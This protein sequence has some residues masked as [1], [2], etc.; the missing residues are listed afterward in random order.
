MYQEIMNHDID[1]AI[2]CLGKRTTAWFAQQHQKATPELFYHYLQASRSGCF[3]EE[4][5]K[6]LDDSMECI[7]GLL[8][9]LTNR[10]APGVAQALNLPR[11]K[12]RRILSM[13][14]YWLIQYHSGNRS[15]MPEQNEVLDIVAGI[16]DN[17]TLKLW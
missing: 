16:L 12:T 5:A 9:Q 1:K 13:M 17:R 8:P 14:L 3:C 6:L 2:D 11:L 4:Y 15:G 10:L 7:T